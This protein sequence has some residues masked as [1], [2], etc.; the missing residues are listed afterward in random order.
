[1]PR[2]KSLLITF[3]WVLAGRSRKCYHSPNHSIAKGD[4]VLEVKVKM[5]FQGYCEVCGHEMIR[6]ALADLQRGQ[7]TE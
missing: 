1:M 4:L 7:A 5:G 2:H 6:V 3:Q